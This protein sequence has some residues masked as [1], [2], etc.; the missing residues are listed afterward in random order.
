MKKA[1]LKDL[2]QLSLQ[3]LWFR[4]S[5]PVPMP[6]LADDNQG[7]GIYNNVMT[8]AE[9]A[10]TEYVLKFYRT[11]GTEETSTYSLV[12]LPSAINIGKKTLIPSQNDTAVI[13]LD[14]GQKLSF[15]DSN[16]FKNFIKQNKISKIEIEYKTGELNQKQTSLLYS[17][18]VQVYE[19]TG[20][21]ALDYTANDPF[22]G[23]DFSLQQFDST[24]MTEFTIEQDWRDRGGSDRPEIGDISFK[25]K[26]NGDNYVTGNGTAVDGNPNLHIYNIHSGNLSYEAYLETE[27]KDSNTNLY[28]YTVPERDASGTPFNYSSEKNYTLDNEKYIDETTPEMQAENQYLAVGLTEFKFTMNWADAYS[29]LARPEINAEYIKNNFKLYKKNTYE[30]IT[31]PDSLPDGET[32]DNY[33]MVQPSGDN[34]TTVTIKR[35]EDINAGGTANEYYLKLNNSE[36]KLAVNPDFESQVDYYAVK[37]E[38]LG[39]HINETDKTYHEGEINLL[40][41]GTTEFKGNVLW[42]DNATQ[43]IRQK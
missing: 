1:S 32:W 15:S 11:M 9:T 43:T 25:V 33:I 19:F 8:S 40:L 3:V 26:Q 14:K 7:V 24:L 27:V 21:N 2:Q 41:S 4:T 42:E 22:S 28:H 36:L 23:H 18:P 16:A 5:P 10:E 17:S 31:F 6:S 12:E 38:N 13:Y 37:S 30:E 20:D 29:S 34:T 39:L 35:L